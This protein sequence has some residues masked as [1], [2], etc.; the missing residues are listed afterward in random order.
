MV[1]DHNSVIVNGKS[2]SV[3]F[4]SFQAIHVSERFVRDFVIILS[5]N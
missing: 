4:Q 2:P 5:A 1:W 3:S